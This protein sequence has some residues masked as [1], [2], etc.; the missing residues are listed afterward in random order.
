MKRLLFA[1]IVIAHG[2]AHA[3]I[4]RWGLSYSPRWFLTA[5]WSVAL[6]GY[7]AAGCGMLRVPALRDG[8]KQL[9]I[10]ATASSILLLTLIGA[11]IGVV[12]AIVDVALLILVFEWAQVQIDADVQ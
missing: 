11:W 9:M 7:V 6:V 3:D 10:A 1:T 2:L 8:W 5:L 4:A 12:G